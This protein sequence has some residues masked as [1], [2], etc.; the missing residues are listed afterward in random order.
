VFEADIR[1]IETCFHKLI[2]VVFE[3]DSIQ[4]RVADVHPGAEHLSTP[5]AF[6]RG[7]RL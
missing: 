1:F 5:P 7:R 6:I 3:P 4:L 2:T